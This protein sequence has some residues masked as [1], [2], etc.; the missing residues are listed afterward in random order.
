MNEWIKR[1]ADTFVSKSDGS[2]HHDSEKHGHKAKVD[3]MKA[4]H[5]LLVVGRAPT[6]EIM[7]KLTNAT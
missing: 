3:W 6:V 7:P 5:P 1:P 2:I 4:L